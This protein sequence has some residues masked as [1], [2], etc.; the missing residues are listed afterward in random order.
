MKLDLF[1]KDT[2]DL[3]NELNKPSLVAQNTD[4]I[5]KLIKDSKYL[6]IIKES[7]N[8][9]IYQLFPYSSAKYNDE[10]SY[11][12]II[13]S[14]QN[15]NTRLLNLKKIN[16]SLDSFVNDASQLN[17]KELQNINMELSDEN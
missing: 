14:S 16:K 17:W 3:L 10:K 4:I 11:D 7:M 8:S 9:S 1:D 5:L 2:R 13:K 12:L 15:L 6:K